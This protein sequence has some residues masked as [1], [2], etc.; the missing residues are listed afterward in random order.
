MVLSSNSNGS[1][2]GSTIGANCVRNNLD[3]GGSMFLKVYSITILLLDLL[4]LIVKVIFAILESI[5]QT[6]TGGAEK[7]VVNEIVLVTGTGHGIGKELAHQYAS[8]GAI[9]VCWD[10]N[11]EQNDETVQELRKIGCKA[12]GYK[13]DVADRDSVLALA[14]KV[15]EEVGDVT[16][17][18]NNAGIM[19]CH[20]LLQHNHQEIRKIFDINVLAHFWMLEAFLPSMIQN[21]RGHVV[22]LSSMAGVMGL[23]NLVPYCASKYAV[24]GLMDA[25]NEELREDARQIEVKFTSIFPFIVDTGLCKKPYTRFPFLLNF[26]P[27]KKA[28][29]AIITAQRRNYSEVSIPGILLHLNSVLRLLPLK[30]AQHLKDFIDSGVDSDTT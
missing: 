22:A 23:R 21:N 24:R 16:I 5:F 15:K 25:L 13:C 12:Y 27:A 8:L 17:L 10:I 29:K 1:S 6:F 7:S 3:S 18:V 28:A 20:P 30:A 4:S 9:V 2:T 19:P 11:Q 14:L 26:V